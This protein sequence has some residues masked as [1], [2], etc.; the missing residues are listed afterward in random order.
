MEKHK[1]RTL[2]A[3]GIAALLTAT[4]ATSLAQEKRR[5]TRDSS[6][7][8][9]TVGLFFGSIE[10]GARIFTP[11]RL[12]PLNHPE[13]G[14]HQF[15]TVLQFHGGEDRLL[16]ILGKEAG[17]KLGVT[18]QRYPVEP[19]TLWPF[20]PFQRPPVGEFETLS[21]LHRTTKTSP[22]P[23]LRAVAYW[24]GFPLAFI[25]DTRGMTL[26]E[27]HMDRG[28]SSGLDVTRAQVQEALSSAGKGGPAK[29]AWMVVYERPR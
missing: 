9:A 25:I 10:E 26:A 13:A 20:A 19:D 5:D 24:N 22:L 12:L 2:H 14:G 23:G 7:E 27:R 21:A 8:Y 1:M 3:L 28:T 6:G 11:T 18:L 4:A 17:L 16:V 29:G 15:P